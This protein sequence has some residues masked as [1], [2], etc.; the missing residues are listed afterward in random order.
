MQTGVKMMVRLRFCQDNTTLF[1]KVAQCY[2][3]FGGMC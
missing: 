3:E 2:I 1:L